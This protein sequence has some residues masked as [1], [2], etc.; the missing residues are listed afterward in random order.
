MEDSDGSES[1][2]GMDTSLEDDRENDA[3]NANADGGKPKSE[4]SRKSKKH[5]H[6][7]NCSHSAKKP[8]PNAYEHQPHYNKGSSAKQKKSKGSSTVVIEGDSGS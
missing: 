6:G 3:S 8:P 1:E 7:A 4:A 2:A 5:R